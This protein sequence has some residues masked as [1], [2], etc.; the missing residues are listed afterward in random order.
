V[1]EALHHA[2]QRGL[3]HRDIKPANILLDAS[4]HP[5]VADFGLALREE[6]FGRGPGFAG[7]PAYMSPEQARGEGH[8]VDAR[9]DVY[10]LGVVFYELLTG[11]CPFQGENLDDLLDQ[12]KTREPRP[13]RR[14]DD[15]IPRELDRICLK[16]L[17]KRASDRYSTALDL[18]EDLRHWQ[19][20]AP[21]NR[22]AAPLGVNVQVMV[23]PATNV[24]P[25][26]PP[27]VAADF[28]RSPIKIVP[29]GLRSFD[30]ADADFFLELLPGPRDRD[31]LP[32]SIRFWRTRIEETDP[33]Q[34]F[35]VGLI[36]GPSGCG[37]SSLVKA[38]LLPR[39][40]EQVL[41][42]YVE[43]SAGETESRLLRGLRRR[44]PDV[45]PGLGLTET[46]AALRRGQGIPA[47]KK[48]LIILD[49]FEQWLHGRREQ[50][51]TELVQAVRQCD[52]E[53]V[54]CI[55]LVRDDFWL[56]VSRFMAELEVELVQ[57]RNTALVDLFDP[58]HARKV[59]ADFGRA[60]DR[61]PE[62]PSAL[63]PE[64]RAFLEQAL[65]GLSQDGRV[66]CIRL[67]LF[68][69]MVK[70]KP[71]TPAT[72]REVGGTEGVGVTF[73]EERFAAPTAP[74]QHRLQSSSVKAATAE[75]SA[76]PRDG[77]Q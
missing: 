24:A 27:A 4:G 64:Q 71:W 52:G 55:V 34:T 31:G 36:Y 42:V 74:P 73:L 54:H 15:T 59:L 67:A 53:R 26:A 29:K 39:L 75:S 76:Q 20:G 47:G 2:H 14:L 50:G 11:Q 66:V 16:T 21:G 30:A 68:A 19:A 33:D 60:F 5:V 65:A 37:K 45:V 48:V 9:T 51:A 7:T 49:Q 58:L 32:E 10:S 41:V 1:A 44:C 40:A 25:G 61:L 18:A 13:P 77:R 69:E 46:L 38:G 17:A 6:D 12:I 43:A 56:A 63:T 70:G 35:A 23:P 8:R 22:E 62:S 28:D 72:L 57:G 3:I